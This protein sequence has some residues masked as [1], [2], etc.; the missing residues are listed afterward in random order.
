MATPV[1]GCGC[2]VCRSDN[3]KNQRLRSSILIRQ[4]GITMLI[5]ASPDVRVQALRENV[6]HL[7]GVL[8]THYHEDHL[9]GLNDLRPYY[10]LNHKKRIPL[11]LS[12]PTN[13]V[14]HMRFGYLIER[15]TPHLLKEDRG[16]LGI[17]G[18]DIRYF[19][20]RQRGVPVNGFRIGNFAYVTD[21]KEYKETIFE[22]LEGVETL[23]V[24]AIH[25][26]G[27]DMHFSLEE[28]ILFGK[29]VGVKKCYFTHIAHDMEHEEANQTLP[30]GFSL[31]YDGLKIVL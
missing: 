8:L 20:Y 4:D 19:T 23:I 31:A 22:D 21:I 29:K 1:A 11:V 3:P 9:G 24:S 7:D 12:E 17:L 10:L 16:Q 6:T 18:M 5:D 14:L 30:E 2:R 27:S 25:K 13:E 26:G 15:F 28:A